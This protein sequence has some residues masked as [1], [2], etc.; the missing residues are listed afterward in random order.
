MARLSDYEDLLADPKTELRKIGANDDIYKISYE[1]GPLDVLAMVR[2]FKLVREK[3]S[4]R[5]FGD[6]I[7]KNEQYVTNSDAFR[8]TTGLFDAFYRE[9][10]ERGSLPVIVILPSRKD[11]EHFRANGLRR[12]QPLLDYLAGTGYRYVDLLDVLTGALDSGYGYSDLF[13]GHYSP[14]ANRLVACELV[15]YVRSL[16]MPEAVNPCDS[17]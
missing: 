15:R 14:T 16:R 8:V 13:V 3:F 9:A 11:V 17:D 10:S 7:I 4:R 2:L 6:G 1:S 5:Y 12:Y